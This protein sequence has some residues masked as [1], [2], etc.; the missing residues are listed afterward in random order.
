MGNA[1]SRLMPAVLF[2]SHGKWGAFVTHG[3]VAVTPLL[4][5]LLELFR[6]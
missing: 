4:R 5:S 3:A 1:N 6:L 2:S